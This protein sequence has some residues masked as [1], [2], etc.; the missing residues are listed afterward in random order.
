MVQWIDRWR[1][2]SDQFDWFSAYLKD[3]GLETQWRVATVG[4]T[5][6][7]AALPI[8]MLWSPYGPDH[9]GTVVLSIAAAGAGLASASVWVIR[10]PSRRQSLLF[11]VLSTGSIAA[12]SLAQS[13]AYAGLEACH[14]FAIIGGFIAYFHTAEHL[15]ANLV[16]ALTCAGV[17]AHQLAVTTGDIALVVASLITVTAVN[18]G[19]PF[20]IHSLVHTLR[21]D[22]RSSDRDSLTGL[23]NRRSFYQSVHEL[24]N[25]RRS[26]A[27]Q[28]LVVVVID[29]DD[30][31]QLNDTWGHATGD[32]ALADVGAAL[33]QHCRT[34]SVIARTGG[35]E[36][37]IAD[38][39]GAPDAAAMTERLRRAI[40]GLPIEV[41]ASIGTASATLD[42]VAGHA[43]R[44]LIDALM[45]AADGAM[46]DAKRAGGN[47]ICH[48]REVS[49]IDSA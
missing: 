6:L 19:V 17:M 13:N 42:T 10:W 32:Q 5:V 21:T 26:A 8:V 41:T 38:I 7:L 49:P 39:D 22:L 35:E 36:F 1:Q 14:I 20:G 4:F 44:Q 9:A 48:R 28:Y 12:S 40:A 43:D 11:C 37:V 2:Q 3:R 18:V 33:R 30:F 16:V 23:L 31:K 47:Q 45:N 15:V 24:L 25:R 46:Y 27:G 29:L 34:T